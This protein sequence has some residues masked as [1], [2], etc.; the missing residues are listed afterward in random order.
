MFKILSFGIEIVA[1]AIIILP[2][3]L[4]LKITLFRN[5]KKSFIFF[6][7][8]MYMAAVY[9][10]TGLPDVT[11]IQIDL[12]FSFVPVIGMISDIKNSILNVILFIPLGLILPFLHNKFRQLK[13]TVLFGSCLTIIIETMQI[14]T[15]RLT[16]INDII[17]NLTGTVIGYYISFK[18]IN[19]LEFLAVKKQSKN[20][21]YIVCITV[22]I[23]MFF[24]Q[25]FV[26]DSFW[27]L[28]F[29]TAIT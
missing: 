13:Y 24:F 28:F 20:T 14:F 6:I 18:S 4:I 19:K 23:V 3:F 25:P 9:V 7:F 5:T 21:I 8:S 12:S 16:D 10:I 1:A 2:V 29:Y 15:F 26:S 17:T 22:F 11:S 27:D